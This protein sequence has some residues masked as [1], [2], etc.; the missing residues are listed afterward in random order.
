MLVLS[1]RFTLSYLSTSTLIPYSIELLK[2][3]ALSI[4]LPNLLSK[5]HH[6]EF[7]I[8]RLWDLFSISEAWFETHCTNIITIKIRVQYKFL[9]IHNFLSNRWFAYHTKSPNEIRHGFPSQNGEQNGW[10][11]KSVIKVNLTIKARLPACP[12]CKIKTFVPP[13]LVRIIWETVTFIVHYL[14][15]VYYMTRIVLE[16]HWTE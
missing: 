16:S 15:I 14:C 11:T 3:W 2:A 9:K 7:Y 4:A 10:F 1:V 12:Q 6:L 5:L 8:I 13:W